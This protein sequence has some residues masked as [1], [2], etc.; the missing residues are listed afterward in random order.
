MS[1]GRACALFG[2]FL[3]FC[4]A[5]GDTIPPSV[6]QHAGDYT[7][8]YYPNGWRIPNP[9]APIRF[10]VQTNRYAF[11]FNATIGH[12]EKLGPIAEPLPAE[13]AAAQGNDL[14]EQLP[15]TDLTFAVDVDGHAFPITLG[16][17]TPEQLRLYRVGKYLQ[18]FDV[19]TLQFGGFPLSA[20]LEGINAWMESYCWPDR[21]S[22]RL[23][24]APYEG[25]LTP[26]LK[27][28]NAIFAALMKIPDAFKTIM[29]LRDD[30]T[31]TELAEGQSGNLAIAV[32]NDAGAGMAFVT[33]PDSG[34]RV[35][36]APGGYLRVE[37]QPI[38][39]RTQTVNAF[40]AVVVPSTD[41]LRDALAESQRMRAPAE[42]IAEGIAPYTGPLTVQYEPVEGWHQILL[43]ESPDPFR[44][45]RVHVRAANRA[46]NDQ[47]VRLNFA[48]IGGP[49]SITGMSPV[50]RDADGY[51]LGV[52]VQISK[53]WH[54]APPWFSGLTMLDVA[55]ESELAFEFD[56][57]YQ[58]WGGV[59]AVSHAQLCLA[60]WGTNQLWDEMAIGSC[61]ESITYDPDVNLQ[62]SM[63]DDMRPLMVWGMGKIPRREWSWTHN[64]GGC[65][66][67]TL[68]TEGDAGRCFLTRQKT[69]YQS[70]GPVLTDVTYAGETANGAIQSRIRTQSWRSDDYVRGLYT[71][72]YDVVKPVDRIERLAFF[73]LGADH[74][75]SFTFGR[76]A[77]GSAAGMDE[78]WEP[79]RGSCSYSRRGE[80]LSGALP[81]VGAF[82]VS[83]DADGTA[84]GDDCGAL[85]DKA[86]IVRAWHAKLAGQDIPQPFYSVYGS[87]NGVKSA[88]IEI[89]PPNAT[90]QLA[91]G[92]FVDAQVEVV[93][94]PQ[95]A[96]DY[97]GPNA[98]LI[99]ALKAQ[100][101]PWGLVVREARQ[102]QL[103]VAATVGTI[104]RRCP[105]TI[106]ADASGN[107]DFTITGGVGYTPVV[108]TGLKTRAPFNLAR[109]RDDGTSERIDQS[110]EVNNDWWQSL[111]HPDTGSWELVFT[112]PLDT[113]DGTPKAQRFR[114][115]NA[116]AS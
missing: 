34:Q 36:L 7:F 80:P 22:F 108:I 3:L 100:T 6:L 14:L 93:L 79:Q 69:L 68:F 39:W 53:N 44:M 10:A 40:A 58:R 111:Y 77:R 91:P 48:K 88:V 4:A 96:D 65:D 99:A 112:L 41:V 12:I 72:R 85:G 15:A 59:P 28:G 30:G 90:T 78:V 71:I 42:V 102:S 83:R 26:A 98:G 76:I 114:F 8:G 92:D 27:R 87:E 82:N 51:P 32:K 45:E 97:Y 43:G 107:A 17:G 66:F 106:K 9:H 20:G 103:E 63:V 49:F 25:H 74:Y 116:S 95:K 52:P 21:F 70:Y 46:A 37:S 29:T 33:L 60:G 57:A 16:A 64:I 73:Q 11:L 56:L 67:L 81:W 84:K 5:W 13:Q 47:I 75:N 109:I 89:G 62:R 54:V 61:G 23:N 113:D 1:P 110:S 24:F 18:H 35:L 19:Q 50:L 115:S 55:R 105:L 2:A 101:E 38:E 31:W 94:L 104:E 86:V